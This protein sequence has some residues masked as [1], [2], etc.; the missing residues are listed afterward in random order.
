MTKH[1]S[2]LNAGERDR[3]VPDPYLEGQRDELDVWLLSRSGQSRVFELSEERLQN[4]KRHI[5][6]VVEDS[7]N[8]FGRKARG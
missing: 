1:E 3:P 7:N 8:W 4:V 6:K 5:A 2:E